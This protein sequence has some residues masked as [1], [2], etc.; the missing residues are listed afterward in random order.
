MLMHLKRRE[1]E[2]G[3]VQGEAEY[4][5]NSDA[6]NTGLM[7]GECDMAGEGITKGRGVPSAN[8]YK[9]KLVKLYAENGLTYFQEFV[10]H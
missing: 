4:F 9:E 7:E 5:S 10:R 3:N 8:G 6:R 2:K 1:E